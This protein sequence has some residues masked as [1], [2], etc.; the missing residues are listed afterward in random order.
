MNV[1]TTIFF[2]EGKFRMSNAEE[3]RI[4]SDLGLQEFADTRT[5]RKVCVCREGERKSEKTAVQAL[6]KYVKQLS[7]HWTEKESNI[8]SI[9]QILNCISR[10]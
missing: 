8:P 9:G 4:N 6:D 1:S 2:R 5:L 7:K 3:G 10:G